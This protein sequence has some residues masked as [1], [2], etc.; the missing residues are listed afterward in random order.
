MDSFFLIRAIIFFIAGV[1]IIFYFERIVKIQY[2]V[3]DRLVKRHHTPH[4]YPYGKSGNK[5]GIHAN[6]VIGSCFL[7]I[8]IIMFVLAMTV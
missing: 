8:S 3:W 1:V 2:R 6:T 7:S 5:H 4:K